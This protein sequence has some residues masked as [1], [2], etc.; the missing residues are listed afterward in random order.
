MPVRH[1]FKYTGPDGK[2]AVPFTDWLQ[3][4]TESERQEYL[5]AQER[6]LTIR[7]DYVDSGALIVDDCDPE[8]HGYVWSDSEAAKINKPNDPVWQKYW[9]RYIAETGT[10]FEIVEIIE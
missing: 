3:T 9:D 8:N 7:Q 5:A 4:L 6:Q 10:V 2:P 1:E